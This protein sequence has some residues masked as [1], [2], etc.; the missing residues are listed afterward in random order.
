MIKNKLDLFIELLDEIID[1]EKDI[2]Y[3][4]THDLSGYELKNDRV[5]LFLTNEK[6]TYKDIFWGVNDLHLLRTG[7]YFTNKK[8][9]NIDFKIFKNGKFIE[10]FQ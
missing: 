7:R 1:S 8:D 9:V 10:L 2:K 4:K 5:Y 3:C 6:E